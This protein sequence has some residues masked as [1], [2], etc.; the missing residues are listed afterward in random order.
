[1]LG[2]RSPSRWWAVQKFHEN[3]AYRFREY[4]E[5]NRIKNLRD[6]QHTVALLSLRKTGKFSLAVTLRYLA[7][8]D[9]YASLHYLFRMS[10]QQSIERIIPDICAALVQ[11]SKGY[12]KVR[13]FKCNRSN[14]QEKLSPASVVREMVGDLAADVFS[15]CRVEGL[16]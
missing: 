5:Q 9:S 7:M 12:V 6:R 11:E 1:M 16:D 14:L 13:H 15:D 8:G 2:M 4:T 3:V 10:K